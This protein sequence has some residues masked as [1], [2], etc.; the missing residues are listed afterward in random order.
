MKFVYVE[1]DDQLLSFKELINSTSNSNI[2]IDLIGNINIINIIIDD[3]NYIFGINNFQI[4]KIVDINDVINFINIIIN[5]NNYII[6]K[7]LYKILSNISD[8]NIL[9]NILDLNTLSHFYKNTNNEFLNNVI[10]FNNQIEIE[11][12]HIN[13]RI[14]LK[15]TP[16]I[17]TAN[18]LVSKSH[19]IYNLF[20]ENHIDLFENKKLLK[21]IS[22]FNYLN[23]LT[24]G[25][26]NFNN[27]IEDIIYKI[28]SITKRP[29]LLKNIN[30]LALNKKDDTRLQVTS[31][32][33]N[34]KIIEI[35]FQSYHLQ[36]I[37]IYLN[38]FPNKNKDFNYHNTISNIIH[39]KD[40]NSSKDKDTVKQQ[41]FF[42]L[43]NNKYSLSKYTEL[44]KL[45][46]LKNKI[47]EQYNKGKVVN[48][49]ISGHPIYFDDDDIDNKL[50]NYI[51]QD[52][53]TNLNMSLLRKMYEKFNTKYKLILYVYDSFIFDI[54][55]ELIDEFLID[56]NIILTNFIY[57][58]KI[59]DNYKELK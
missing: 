50:L 30:F 53:E 6:V 25:G 22:N 13:K 44:N 47:I 38:L 28:N 56:M 40:I 42:M 34:G 14:G 17:L 41:I 32:F 52:F 33:E 35:D 39:N 26:I 7:D 27:K 20:K 19:N 57:N 1:F 45:H 18:K 58:I 55:S 2:Y 24:S 59:G 46:E 11:R 8:M 21:C 12:L 10:S 9:D 36:L 31:R 23:K 49:L 51:M 29:S 48:S 4:I 15:S 16:V 43:Y 5:N 54:P 3:I 37:D